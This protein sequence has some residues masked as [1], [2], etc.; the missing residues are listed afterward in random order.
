[1]RVALQEHSAVAHGRP[2][3]LRRGARH[4]SLT[5]RYFLDG[6]AAAWNSGWTNSSSSSRT[7]S[8]ASA[9]RASPWSGSPSATG[10]RPIGR[11][12]EPGVLGVPE[13]GPDGGL[14]VV[15]GAI[16]FEQLG[17]H[18]VGGPALW[19]TLAAGCVEG[20]VTG[21]RLVGGV[22]HAGPDGEPIVVEHAGEVDAL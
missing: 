8:A 3:R 6:A 14:G 13:A 1:A 17:A 18:L 16:V 10:G 19:S 20:A 2:P 5:Y 21:D 15:G 11:L 12:A 4:R 22:E 7:P 9:R